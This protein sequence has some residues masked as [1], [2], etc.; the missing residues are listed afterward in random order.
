MGW[1]FDVWSHPAAGT[2]AP[3]IVKTAISSASVTARNSGRGDGRIVLPPRYPRD[4][5][6]ADQQGEG[7][8][9][10][11]ILVRN[12]NDRTKERRSLVR[13]YRE[14]TALP[15][16]DL[17]PIDLPDVLDPEQPI[18]I[19]CEP[20][21]S[22]ALRDAMVWA[23]DFPNYRFPDWIWGGPNLLQNP[24]F[25]EGAPR[26]G[27][28]TVSI[29]GATGGTWTFTYNAATTAGIAFNATSVTVKAAVELLA[30]VDSCIVAGSGT[31]VSPWEIQID[32][33]P[34]QFTPS[35][36]GAGLTPAGP[37]VYAQIGVT[38]LGAVA[39]PSGW[40]KS[41][42]GPAFQIEHGPHAL[43]SLRL[44]I[45]PGEV[46]DTGTY[47]M[48]YNGDP[49]VNSGTQYPGIQQLVPVQEGMVL[50]GASIRVRT[51]SGTDSWAIVL[52]DADE[53]LIT[54]SP[55]SRVVSTFAP[56]S[57]YKT[58]S[59]PG[60]HVVGQ[61][62]KELIFRH[63]WVPDTGGTA[64]AV[65]V[66]NATLYLGLPAATWGD[67]LHQLL[68]DC[69]VNHVADGR[70][71]MLTWLDYSSFTTALDSNG[72]AW[73]QFGAATNLI[74]FTV[75]RGWSMFQVLEAGQEQ[76]GYEWRISPKATP[77]G[78]FLP[79]ALT[80]DL[81]AYNPRVGLVGG[82]GTDRRADPSVAYFI[83]RQGV[84]AGPLSFRALE[85]N[86]VFAEGADGLFAR[87][88]DAASITAAGRI[89][90][91]RPDGN[92]TSQATI[93]ALA[94]QNLGELLRQGIGIQLA[95]PEGAEAPLPGV[96]VLLGDTVRVSAPPT[97]VREPHRLDSYSWDWPEGAG[98][99]TATAYLSS[100]VLHGQEA[101]NQ[102][103]VRLLERAAVLAPPEKARAETRVL[104]GGAKAAFTFRVAAFNARPESKLAADL[105]CSG[106][107]DQTTLQLA[108]DIVFGLAPGGGG[109]VLLSEGNY[110]VAVPGAG[111]AITGSS[112][113]SWQGMGSNSTFIAL[114]LAPGAGAMFNVGGLMSMEGISFI[115]GL[116]QLFIRCGG[117][118][119]L[120]D[121]SVTGFGP[122]ATPCIEV[123]GDS[124]DLSHSFINALVQISHSWKWSVH[125]N[126][127]L[128]GLRIRGGCNHW[129]IHD[130]EEIGNLDR[131]CIM[132]SVL[133]GVFS[134]YG[135]IHH[136]TIY[137]PNAPAA[138]TW[139][140]VS[141]VGLPYVIQ[142][143]IGANPTSWVEFDNNHLYN[144]NG[145]ATYIENTGVLYHHN[146]HD[147]IQR[148]GAH[149]V[150]AS[151]SQIK[152]NQFN[153][154]GEETT[155]T[156]DGV[157]VEGTTD[158]AFI[159]GND[160]LGRTAGSP[161]VRNCINLVGAAVTKSRVWHNV[162]NPT[163]VTA[164]IT[165]TG[166]GT[167]F[168]AAGG[169]IN[170]GDNLLS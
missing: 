134:S 150:D 141:V 161:R 113:V 29:V 155:N 140:L 121:I 51:L 46:A 114:Y 66:D 40:T 3:R 2:F 53:N 103:V 12:P 48:Y 144:A 85:G 30:T 14:G 169:L 131:E 62:V 168:T 152:E 157:I 123:L 138:G 33:P 72:N 35:V 167:L 80:H 145:D 98:S 92:V 91:Y 69:T 31:L 105:V 149:L 93:Q 94:D 159:V 111:Q 124:F 162:A 106:I 146:H 115:A 163:A 126:P 10:G 74:S 89:E 44:T 45:P 139:P 130:N 128:A 99:I 142:P 47:A 77:V 67:I 49:G 38:Q 95:V 82:Q 81:R 37:G 109:R 70:V 59:I 122:T 68:D 83:G 13:I 118:V 158:R 170:P 151:H 166:T 5:A 84:L 73:V 110:A 43:D 120:R 18:E 107:N 87:A 116:P 16:E 15:L 148:H 4:Q 133:D 19:M 129:S 160:F 65:Q 86:A 41:L 25:E 26:P 100:E 56:G 165:N 50:S 78:G 71:G 52:R 1:R 147:R 21:A 7:G 11:L 101:V 60:L 153:G 79:G 9:L 119:R 8:H 127:Y 63:A 135:H 102:G 58:H 76:F 22:A 96:A 55:P 164:F 20:L 136:N 137:G 54:Q 88:E 27:I 64:P 154:I 36:S 132:L 117:S 125:H 143:G 34:G 108:N 156:Y 24:G 112:G 17:V 28:F 32:A 75:P 23:Y 6:Q 42:K 57:P 104:S 61:G 90:S 39:I 97:L